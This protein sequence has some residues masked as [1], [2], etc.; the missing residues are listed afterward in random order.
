[1]LCVDSVLGVR[2]V[3]GEKFDVPA[4]YLNTATIGLPFARAADTLVDT[5]ARWR[6]GALQLTDFDADVVAASTAWARL[7]GAAPSDVATGP[8]C[9]SWSGSSPPACRTVPG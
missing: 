1:M 3:F 8:V 5:I 9:R 7:V 6:A 2:E 4:D